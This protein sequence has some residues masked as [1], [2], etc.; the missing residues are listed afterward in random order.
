MDVA[1]VDRDIAY[2]ATLV[3]LCCKLLFLSFVFQTYVASV[4]DICFKRFV[5]PLTYVTSVVSGCLKSRSGVAS[6]SSPSAYVDWVA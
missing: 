4:L 2:V 3:N 1:T 5:C 6:F